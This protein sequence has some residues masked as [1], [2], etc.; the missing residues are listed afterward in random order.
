MRPI[1]S[2]HPVPV[3]RSG[4]GWTLEASAVRLP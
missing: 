3:A 2:A 4:V 1:P